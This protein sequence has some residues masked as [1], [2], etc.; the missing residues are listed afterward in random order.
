MNERLLLSVPALLGLIGCVYGEAGPPKCA[1]TKEAVATS[2]VYDHAPDKPTGKTWTC[3]AA[4]PAGKTR[5]LLYEDDH[6][7]LKL[8]VFNGQLQRNVEYGCV[9]ACGVGEKLDRAPSSAAQ[10]TRYSYSCYNVAERLARREREAAA[11]ARDQQTRE[12]ANEERTRTAR[13]QQKPSALQ[14]R[15]E[16]GD[17]AACAV[18]ASINKCQAGDPDACDSAGNAYAGGLG[19]VRDVESATVFWSQACRI[20]PRACVGYGVKI[21]QYMRNGQSAQVAQQ[22]FDAGC[23]ADADQCVTAGTLFLRGAGGVAQDSTKARQYFQQGC[24]AGSA[25]ACQSLRLR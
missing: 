16:R 4:C 19:G 13:D 12:I 8:M 11:E 20:A 22:F 17:N 10:G 15:C 21:V 14:P 3:E 23:Q 9:T 2:D 18:L 25:A 7:E 5:A 24:D 1:A 6:P